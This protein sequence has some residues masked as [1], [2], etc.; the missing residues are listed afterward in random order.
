MRKVLSIYLLL[1]FSS[2]L[3]IYSCKRPAQPT[4]T[5]NYGQFP[6]AVGKIMINK[7]ATAGCHNAASY[8]NS[9]GLLL[10]TWEHLM[11]G[12]NSGA[13]VIAY[14]PDFSPLLYFVNTNPDRGIVA[15]PTMP[16]DAS[17]ANANTLSDEEYNTLKSWVANGAPDKDGN[18]PFAT[19]ADTRQKFYLTQQGCDQVAV[20]DAGT[21]LVMRYI[22]VGFD[23]ANTESPH[24]LRTDAA[25]KFAYVS[26]LN[27]T[28]IQK[29]D[30]QTDKV[31][32]NATLGTGSWNIL[33]V[34]P[35]DTAL[36]TTD[37]TSNGRVLYVSTGSMTNLPG[38]TGSGAGAFVYP[39][40]IASDA[41][42]DTCFITAQYGNVVYRY[43]PKIP[44]YKR[45]SINGN[46][47]ATTNSGDNSSPNPHEIL[48]SP[49]YSKYFLTCEGTDEVR[50]LDAHTDAILA[51]IPVGTLPQ[52]FAISHTKPYIFVSCM[53][54][55]NSATPT[56]RRGSVY[57]INYNTY[58]VVTVLNG[59]FYQPHGLTVDDRTGTLLVASTNANPDGPA[60]HHATA[61]GGRAGWYTV[62][63]INTLLPRSNK[64]YQV[65]VM[66]YSAD[67]RFK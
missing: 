39:H 53:E 54:D 27:G 1:A 43:A 21:N 9:A 42:F 13:S 47:P 3:V 33:Y 32:S 38:L 28:G 51:V 14:S 44:H 22:S 6:D 40:G 5:P 16:Y 4:S 15:T 25:G 60:P 49:D 56:G 18:I 55:V 48:M 62:Y 61:C 67:I 41:T 8:Q 24:C 2:I 12:G 65:T 46:P 64:R 66:P 31:V 20:I 63:D 50:V 37:W 58:E 11:Q 52:E 7:C 59:D 19:N 26:F 36:A 30:L 29:I 17:G 34:A 23:P 10:D 57:V 35:G 45:I